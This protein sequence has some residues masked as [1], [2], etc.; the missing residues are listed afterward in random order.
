[1]IDVNSKLIGVF[2][3]LAEKNTQNKN[4][5]MLYVN[6]FTF[7]IHPGMWDVLVE[8]TTKSNLTNKSFLLTEISSKT[9]K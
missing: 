8:E 5:N 6:R 3:I 2:K 1:M 7:A 4:S 9:L